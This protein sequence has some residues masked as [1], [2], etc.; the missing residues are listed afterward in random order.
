MQLH[1]AI[2]TVKSTVNHVTSA[3][4][5]QAGCTYMPWNEYHIWAVCKQVLKS[6]GFEY[7][8]KHTRYK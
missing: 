3:A 8:M 6:A 1:A 2:F 4:M 5:A 7:F